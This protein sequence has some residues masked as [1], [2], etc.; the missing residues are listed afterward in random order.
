LRY[1]CLPALLLFLCG[2]IVLCEAPNTMPHQPLELEV[3]QEFNRWQWG[4]QRLGWGLWLV[5][6]VAAVLGLL[7]DGPLSDARVESAGTAL[8]VDFER[9]VRRHAPQRVEFTIRPPSSRAAVVHLTLPSSFMNR[10]TI[11]RIEPAPQVS[12]VAAD[13]TRFQFACRPESRH[14][15]I[16]FHLQYDAIGKVQ[17]AARAVDDDPVQFDQVVYP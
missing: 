17:G 14:V 9:F 4:A 16:V 12:A 3:D 2:R 10:V 7:G 11:Q 8:S 6:L 15:K 1:A 13:G 5:I